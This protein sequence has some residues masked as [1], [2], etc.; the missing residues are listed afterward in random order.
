[1]KIEDLT[2]SMRPRNA[3]TNHGIDTVEQLMGLTQT[4]WSEI[5]NLGKESMA[6]ILWMFIYLM[7]GNILQSIKDFDEKFPVGRYTKEGWEE[8]THNDLM[9]RAEKYDKIAKI[10][11]G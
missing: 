4:Q 1:M 3:L 9:G 10:V 5:K 11:A 6:E 7:N 2:L 8:R